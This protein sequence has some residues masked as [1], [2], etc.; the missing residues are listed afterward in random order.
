MNFV[1]IGAGQLGSRHLQGLALLKEPMDIYLVDPFDSS[2]E[3]SKN[4]FDEVDTYYNKNIILLNT[5]EDIPKEIEFAIISTTS[6]YRLSALKSLLNQSKVK[7][8]LLEKFLFP[9]ATE[10]EEAKDLVKDTITYVNCPRRQFKGYRDLKNI[11]KGSTKK[12]LT[13]KG[14]KWNLGSNA[15]HFLDLF[16]YL[17][18][19][20]EMTFDKQQSKLIA[21]ESKHKEY[22]EFTGTLIGKTNSGNVLEMHCTEDENIQFTIELITDEGIYYINEGKGSIQYKSTIKDFPV[23]YQSQL[24]NRVYE[25]LKNE[26]ICNLTPIDEAISPH[27]LLIDIFNYFLEDRKGIV[28]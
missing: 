16:N 26:G 9:Y 28:T 27:L 21:K 19:N 11:L 10:Y 22:I 8:L 15:I 17:N 4:R 20:E 12:I 18:N 5:V 23:N 1:I 2:L 6:L 14:D 13:I 24:T 7:Y 3:T 25:Q